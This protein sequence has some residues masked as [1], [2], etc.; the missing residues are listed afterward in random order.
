M[1][2]E[3]FYAAMTN[4]LLPHTAMKGDKL[5]LQVVP[6]TRPVENVLTCL[7]VT[8]D[9]LSEAIGHGCDTIVCFHPLIFSPVAVLHPTTRVERCIMK[10]VQ[11]SIRIISVH[12]MFDALPQGTNL[13]LAQKL[14]LRVVEALVPDVREAGYGMG[15]IAEIEPV[16]V[17]ELCSR[18]A[19]VCGAPVRYCH[20]ATDTMQR[21]A[22]VAGSGASYLDDAIASDA[23]CFITADVKYHT[24]HEATER[25]VL[26]DPG[27]FEME[28]FVPFGLVQLFNGIFASVHRAPVFTATRH[29][30][31]PVRYFP[32]T[33]QMQVQR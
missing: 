8:D 7:E 6:D 13:I 24:F 21:I 25:I 14:G 26:I 3:E 33:Q 11:A 4:H 18:V 16:T 19:R 12:T 27:H 29:S 31:N 32:H 15:V 23:D 28:Q 2:P 30:T 17:A 10:A 5:G 20:G 1:S 9:V 22:I